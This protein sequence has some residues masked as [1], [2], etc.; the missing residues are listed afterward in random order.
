MRKVTAKIEE[1]EFITQN[2]ELQTI[3]CLNLSLA[4]TLTF[5]FSILSALLN[6]HVRPVVL[7]GI[8]LIWTEQFVFA[9]LLKPMG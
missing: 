9:Q 7:T 2:S 4:S 6:R 3:F 8:N 5:P 1:R